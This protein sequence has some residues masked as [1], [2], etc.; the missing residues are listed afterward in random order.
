MTIIDLEQTSDA[1]NVTHKSAIADAI[2]ASVLARFAEAI[3]PAK[4]ELASEKI[5]EI[6]QL[7]V[8]RGQLIDFL[9]AEKGHALAVVNSEQ[10][11]EF[12]SATLEHI[13]QQINTLDSIIEKEIKNDSDLANEKKILLSAPGVNRMTAM[14][15][16]TSLPELGKVNN[17][18]IA[19]LTGVAP[20][21]KRHFWGRRARVRVMIHM[22]TLTA[23][24]LNPM[25][26]NFYERLVE[27]GKQ[28]EIAISACMRKLII[29]LNTLVQNNEYWRDI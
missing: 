18:V 13:E 25:L 11:S 3:Q 5:A 14:T 22:A 21:G 24:T 7:L 26:K 1:T 12:I 20:G 23:I 19:A 2:E 27:S 15:L 8:R 29:L 6:Q 9:M 4:A 10:V 28:P 17:K 16:I